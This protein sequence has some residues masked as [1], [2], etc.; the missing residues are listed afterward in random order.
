MFQYGALDVSVYQ[1]QLFLA[2]AE[3]CNFTRASDAMHISQPTLSKRIQNFEKMI[4][5]ELFD[6]SKRPLELTPAGEALYRQL[7]P[8][9]KKMEQTLSAIHKEYG[10]SVIRFSVGLPDSGKDLD[11]FHKA[12][13]LLQAETENVSFSWQYV[14]IAKWRETLDDGSIDVMMIL[15][16]EEENFEKSWEWERVMEV[17]KLVCMLK[18]NPL[19]AKESITYEDLRSQSFVMNPVNSFP[20]YH[21]FVR[22]QMLKHGGFEP[23]VAR[24]APNP[25]NLIAN[26]EYD[27]EVVVCDM[28]LRDVDSDVIK[29]FELPDTYSGL[30][31]VWRKDNKNPYIRRY[32]EL[33]RQCI[34]VTYPGTVCRP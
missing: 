25:H 30:D 18:T 21:R 6:R 29:C 11:S 22:E 15:R 27:D 9:T 7:L 33:S 24:Y 20:A 10:K 1:I 8:L 2:V 34:E 23:K 12:G 28:Y 13:K 31:A 32:I 26:I 16:M 17:P 5:V 3:E 4:G 19:C 14:P